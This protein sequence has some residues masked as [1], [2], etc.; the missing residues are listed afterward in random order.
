TP[1]ARGFF[2][3]RKLALADHSATRLRRWRAIAASRRAPFASAHLDLS[4][5]TP[6]PSAPAPAVSS[7][8]KLRSARARWE[9]SRR[10]HWPLFS[11][12]KPTGPWPFHTALRQ[13]QT[14]PCAHPLASPRV[15][16]EPC[17]ELFPAAFLVRSAW[18]GL[19]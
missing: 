3:A 17:T 14:D 19:R 5:G 7:A 6:E 9:V 15:A 13:T 2:S 1:A 4:P 16:P 18:S 10:S 12:Q 11:L 8:A